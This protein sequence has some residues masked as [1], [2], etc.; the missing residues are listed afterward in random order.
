[1]HRVGVMNQPVGLSALG[2]SE[3]ERRIRAARV[4]RGISQ[5]ELDRLFAADGLGKSAGRLERGDKRLTL[6]RALLDGLVRHLRVPEAWFT[7][8]SV[9]ALIYPN[10][11]TS[12]PELLEATA[13]RLRLE[14]AEAATDAAEALSRTGGTASPTR[15]APS[16]RRA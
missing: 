7:S 3:L 9:D 10:G 6:N 13:A 5:D 12:L 1:M 2:R 14:L 16:R 4:L 11:E 8:E 15:A